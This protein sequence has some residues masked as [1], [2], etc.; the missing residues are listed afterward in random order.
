MR[1]ECGWR[2][3]RKRW[4]WE[5]EDFEKEQLRLDHGEREL[6]FYH[7]GESWIWAV[8]N[9]VRFFRSLPIEILNITRCTARS[10]RVSI[11]RIVSLSSCRHGPK[12]GVNKPVRIRNNRIRL[13]LYM[14]SVTAVIDIIL[15]MAIQH[16][17]NW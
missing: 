3:A 14:Y 11:V 10:D 1:L 15:I 6:S 12:P 13:H 17:V 4:S 7:W 16:M 9:V 5:F 8:E 2:H